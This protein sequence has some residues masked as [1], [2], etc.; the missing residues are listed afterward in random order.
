V[1]SSPTTE[2]LAALDVAI[3]RLENLAPA[4]SGEE[5]L[6]DFN[7]F[8]RT[9]LVER[10]YEL[11][12]GDPIDAI[13]DSSHSRS[14]NH[15]IAIC[16]LRALNARP[17]LLEELDIKRDALRLFDEAFAAEIYP[18]LGLET[19]T[20]TFEK[21]R[22]LEDAV[23]QVETDLA[24]CVANLTSLSELDGARRDISGRLKKPLPAALLKS[25]V[26]RPLIE[27]RLQDI[28][29]AASDYK[30]ADAASKI[31]AFERASA[32]IG[33][34]EREARA[35]RTYYTQ[36]ILVP[37]AAKLQQ[38]LEADFLEDD[39]NKPVSVSVRPAAKR[40]PLDREGSEIDVRLEV[41][42]DGPGVAREVTI[43]IVAT[44]GVEF[45]NPTRGVGDL[46]RTATEVSL[47]AR[48][49]ASKQE[50][51]LLAMVTWRDGRGLEHHSEAELQLKAQNLVDWDLAASLEPYSLE[52]VRTEDQLVGRRQL[53]DELIRTAQ[54]PLPKSAFLFGQK[55][56]GKTSIARALV[57]H[58][59][60]L[61]SEDVFA[62][63]VDMS[64]VR[65]TEPF[66]T[67]ANLGEEL[68]YEFRRRYPR[69]AGID[70]PECS[71]SLRPLTR[72]LDSLRTIAPEGRFT[73]VIDEFDEIPI[74]LFKRGAIG[75][76]FFASLRH[77]TEVEGVHVVLVG[78]ERM[79]AI[80]DSQGT[81]LNK[82]ETLPVDYFSRQRDW[83]DYTDLV[84]A[85]A[86]GM[87]EISEGAV[88]ALFEATAGHPFFTNLICGR[89]YEW[90]V[91]HRDSDITNHEVGLAI[92]AAVARAQQ[93][94][95][96]HFWE[97]GI[98]ES[99]DR[100]REVTSM[101]RR[102]V[103]LALGDFEDATALR[104]EVVSRTQ[105]ALG[106]NAQAA[107]DDL[108][109]LIARRVLAADGDV[110]TCKV[111]L[112]G[113]WLRRHG[114]GD[115]SVTY[116]DAAEIEDYLAGERA[117]V[118]PPPLSAPV[119]HE[120]A[121]SP[122][123][124]GE[125]ERIVS[126]W[127][128]FNGSRISPEAALSWLR[129][130]SDASE[131]RLMLPILAGLTYFDEAWAREKVRVAHRSVRAGTRQVFEAAKGDEPTRSQAFAVTYLGG[132]GKSGARVARLY[133]EENN[134][135][136]ARNVF[137]ADRLEVRARSL[138]QLQGIVF[139]D[140][141]IGT[142]SNLE[143]DLEAFDR[144]HG[145]WLRVLDVPMFLVVLVAYRR[146]VQRVQRAIDRLGLP[147]KLHVAEEL[148]D[149][150]D[151]CFGPKSRFYPDEVD[152]ENA[153]SVV[154]RIGKRL[155]QRTPLGYGDLQAA[156]V[157]DWACPNNTLPILRK[158]GTDWVPLFERAL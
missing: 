95:F 53:L 50:A 18:A 73:I 29:R 106:M 97:D 158:R 6:E 130:F 66:R 22:A 143:S 49:S 121:P 138:D 52:P 36:S 3:D 81:R 156:V 116:T 145:D 120:P 141:F 44:D 75:D 114:R 109:S 137:G 46:R 71:E 77:L 37:L 76:T 79:N 101:R 80:I 23:Q 27:G 72:Y 113:M 123:R 94:Y 10:G 15:F 128:T 91:E 110:V 85:P 51:S 68:A 83:E 133:A 134:I 38:L 151:R 2:T 157:F 11:V 9:V 105:S 26:E 124:Y 33:A 45:Q 65:S 5:L 24:A 92:T 132:D 56:I 127:G 96:A 148:S 69:F 118:E 98:V 82:F 35:D 155:E 125:V 14:D 43:E 122:V 39:V 1:A 100:A 30:A 90:A 147:M 4:A 93:N 115:I 126:K 119:P 111:P 17:S 70:I 78:G 139:V 28:F 40:Y 152:R 108:E 63:F 112:F 135:H 117:A 84:R 58:C 67:V 60:Q 102:K 140:D 62:V 142:G 154:Q 149:D 32:T 87:L 8:S 103:L 13:F 107:S 16:L 104:D 153:R 89:L 88:S 144:D 7:A 74:E 64:G 131:E 42:T 41:F 21:E 61:E 31:A 20:Q 34:Y 54:S 48:V 86:E 25:F 59:Q 146:G 129:Q 99:D 57:S 47:P 55:R 136:R 19:K 12:D 150:R